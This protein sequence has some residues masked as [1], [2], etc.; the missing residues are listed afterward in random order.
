MVIRH[1]EE[2]VVL[3]CRQH[4]SYYG[5][6]PNEW[7]NLINSLY[8]GRMDS[9]HDKL[10]QSQNIGGIQLRDLWKQRELELRQ[11]SGTNDGNP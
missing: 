5:T 3:M 2:N 6:R 1:D 7:E 4:H 10:L 9:L 11:K 8:P